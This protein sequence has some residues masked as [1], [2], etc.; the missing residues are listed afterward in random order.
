MHAQRRSVR[1]GGDE[2]RGQHAVV[3][4]DIGDETYGVL[5]PFIVEGKQ[6]HSSAVRFEGMPA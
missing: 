5:L 1:L 2:L 3:L 4:A 6:A